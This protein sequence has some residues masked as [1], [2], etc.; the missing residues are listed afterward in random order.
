MHRIG[1]FALILALAACQEHPPANLNPKDAAIGSDG[2]TANLDASEDLDAAE[3]EDGSTPIDGAIEEDAGAA[4]A[5]END[6]AGDAA[7]GD[8]T[9]GDAGGGD[10]TMI[11]A[12]GGDAGAIDTGIPP[13]SG[14]LP[15]SDGDTISDP[16]E[17]D[18]NVD[19][20]GDGTPDTADLDSDGDGIPDSVEAGDT[21]PTT[22]PVDSDGDGT[23]DFQD[24]DSDG[25]GILDQVEGTGDPDGDGI[26][27][28]LDVDSDGDTIADEDE[29]T[30]D[31]DGDGIPNYLDDDSDGDGIS[32]R[33]EAGDLD[34]VSRPIDFD[35]DGVPNFL[36]LDSD[37]DT[38]SDQ[39]ETAADDDGDGAPNYLD[40]DSDNDSVIDY[41]E[42]GDTD[43]ST[44]PVDTDGDGLE[45]YRDVD[46]DGDTI[47]DLVERLADTDGDGTPDRRD[48]DSDGDGLPDA[49]EA[50]DADLATPP[51]DTDGDGRADFL[52]LD[53]D[54]DGL[55]DNVETGCPGSTDRLRPDSD[56]DGFVD[57]AE[58][59]YGSDPCSAASGIDDFYFV[60]PPLGPLQTAPLVFDDTG[61][62]RADLAINVDT[63]GSMGGE[64]ANLRASLSNVIIPG[65]Q[66]AV[67]DPAFAVSSFEDYPIDPFGDAPSGDRPFRLGTRAT[68][69]GA[70]AQ[71]AVNGLTT[72]NGIDLPEAGIESLY[73]LG[74]GAGTAWTG[75]S[76]APFDPSQN[77]IP[78]VADG[79]IGG[80]GFRSDSLPIIVHVTDATSHVRDE[81]LGVDP[82]ITAASVSAARLALSSIGARVITIANV[83]LPRP[84]DFAITDQFFTDQCDGTGARFFGTIAP[85]T[86]SD[87]DWFL[88]QGAQAGDVVS[89]ETMA[90]PLGS[91]LDSMVGVYAGAT[92]LA[93]NDDINPGVA[94]DSQLTVTLSGA[95]PFYV[96][97]TSWDNP[98]F[99]GSGANTTGFYFANITVNGAGA[100][101]SPRG[102]PTADDGGSAATATVLSTVP[103]GPPNGVAQCLTECRAQ[104][105]DEPFRLP[106]GISELTNAVIP[107]CA[108]DEF[109]AA[110][111]A[112]CGAAECCTGLSGTGTPPNAAGMCPLS[113]EIDDQGTGIDTAVVA[114]IE[115]LV[116][117][118]TFTI[119]TVTRPD[120]T[121][122]IDT[123][124]FIHG[125]IPQSAVTPSA[126]APIPN[127]ADLIPPSPELDS[128]ENV[129]P[130]TI[131]TFT[132][133]ARNM[134]S[135]TGFA[136][137]PAASGPQLFRAFI[138]VV[139]DGVTVVDTRDVI[140]IVPPA[141]VGGSN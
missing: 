118:S 82:G 17:G 27:S 15:D 132:V 125:V 58:L 71:T 30:A 31:P 44:P 59:A 57:P 121:A 55:A 4:D 22:P 135:A 140:I 80:A 68:T 29:G 102:C 87:V 45:D 134:S 23:P 56:L 129:V 24:D 64:I 93:F 105:Q 96:A 98:D 20:D 50:G 67:P 19:T 128:F 1:L 34:V 6:D 133:N 48:L 139:A 120:P 124:C 86:A 33:I 38:I 72:R 5:G 85:P 127:T 10:A 99:N 100:T 42:A 16:D 84:S 91:T 126:C 81:Y 92:R 63:T 89:V 114:G 21:D 43:L 41:D 52:D 28:Y 25:D 122:S 26:P 107:A 106:Y 113:F 60:L 18:G 11:D 141:P 37:D 35:F 70:A 130:G 32:D 61:I 73:Q 138:D 36:D 83:N 62:D 97:I 88:L 115:A 8:A 95:G 69:D 74:T 137:A 117:Y 66:A 101:R 12:G 123:T 46:S 111:P 47:G 131:L 51:V 79:S 65:V 103:L 3:A 75:G 49:L 2:S 136:C 77:L 104:L 119:T 110:R 116:S 112:G 39:D 54:D 53:S 76:V 13:D 90:Q 14:V 40:I 78:G 94:T 108:W 7:T 109:G 9:V